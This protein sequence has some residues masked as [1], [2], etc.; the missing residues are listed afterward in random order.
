MPKLVDFSNIKITNNDCSQ[1]PDLE[2]TF[3]D[4]SIQIRKGTLIPEDENIRK[5][6]TK[7]MHF[8]NEQMKLRE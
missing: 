2:D 1:I 4:N 5:K 3:C 8:R 7:S 6:L